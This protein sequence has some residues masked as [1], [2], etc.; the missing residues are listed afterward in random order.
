MSSIQLE[1]I[2]FL[3][4]PFWSVSGFR[5]SDPLFQ[6]QEHFDCDSFAA[7]SGCNFLCLL[8][9]PFP[10][11]RFLW[12]GWYQF[13]VPVQLHVHGVARAFRESR[14]RRPIP[15][16][17]RDL[18]EKRCCQPVPVFPPRQL[19]LL[20]LLVASV[21]PSSSISTSGFP[22]W[23]TSPTS[24]E[25]LYNYSALWR[26]NICHHLLSVFHFHQCIAGFNGLAFYIPFNHSTFIKSFANVG[27]LNIYFIAVCVF[28]IWQ[29]FRVHK[30][31]IRRNHIKS[32]TF[33][34]RHYGVET[35]DSFWE[36]LRGIKSFFV[37]NGNEFEPT[38][39]DCGASA[40][41]T[42]SCF[43]NGC[44]WLFLYQ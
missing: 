27:K 12:S 21:V 22:T 25:E 43:P 42:T 28:K 31:T 13:P 17:F 29:F 38:L 5:R 23:I 44:L 41:I 30:N 4:S 37:G 19:F 20:R 1:F 7:F 24:A 8:S 11:V 18:Q 35:H 34:I 39:K 26:W 15:V 16:D 36:V 6:L 2:M 3:L 40:T 10:K 32:F 9:A 33:G 14:F